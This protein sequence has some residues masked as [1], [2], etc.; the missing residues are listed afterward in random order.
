MFRLK[1]LVQALQKAEVDFVIVGGVAMSAHGSA[2]VTQDLD[3]CYNR[4]PYNL[5]RIVQALAPLHPRLR[6]VSEPEGLP[7]LWDAETLRHGLN[8]TLTTRH[9]DLDLLGEVSGLGAYEQ[10]RH[11]AERI[12]LFGRETWVLGLP[13]LI[14]SK[15][16]A[17]RPKDLRQ[18]PELRALFALKE[19]QQSGGPETPPN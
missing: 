12:T 5:E 13:G 14:R 9:G 7:F 16:A 2:H 8:F 17:A 18:I 11:A 3:V 1:E 4:T 19:K 6:V 10:V 15:Q